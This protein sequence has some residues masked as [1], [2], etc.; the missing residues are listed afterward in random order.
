MA[1]VKELILLYT[2]KFVLHLEI[3]YK[4]VRG[5]YFHV[6]LLSKHGWEIIQ[7]TICV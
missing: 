1:R 7:Y 4:Y 6:T 3:S 2:D 5:K